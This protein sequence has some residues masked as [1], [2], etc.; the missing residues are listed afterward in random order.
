MVAR[1]NSASR[2]TCGDDE[3]G[4]W[5]ATER[6]SYHFLLT[7][8]SWPSRAGG[9]GYTTFMV[10]LPFHLQAVSIP[11]ICILYCTAV[12]KRAAFHFGSISDSTI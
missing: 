1:R 9:R 7:N 8:T 6:C 4:P 12:H 2:L 3:A 10:S 5:A 11:Q